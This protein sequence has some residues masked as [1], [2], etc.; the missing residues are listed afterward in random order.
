MRRRWKIFGGVGLALAVLWAWNSTYLVGRA[1][2]GPRFLAH[3]GVHQIAAGPG[4]DAEA[5]GANPVGPI[6]HDFIANTLR[7]M[8]A[9]FDHGAE[10]VELDVHLTRD[11][12]FAVFHDW[13]LECQIDGVGV[14]RA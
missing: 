8:R 10:V 6:T 3:R 9:A 14:T 4:R 5:C 13:R 2:D 12:V 11:G 7:S 1:G